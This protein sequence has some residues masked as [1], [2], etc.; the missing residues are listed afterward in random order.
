MFLFFVGLRFAQY[1][2]QKHL[3]ILN[4]LSEVAIQ[5]FF[6]EPSQL[7]EALKKYWIATEH[8]KPL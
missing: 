7:G 5:Y 2:K 1:E 4:N 6:I 3:P 8:D